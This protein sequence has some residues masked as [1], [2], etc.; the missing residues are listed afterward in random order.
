M[1]L[2]KNDTKNIQTALFR[3]MY[4]LRILNENLSGTS[5]FHFSAGHFKYA[6]V[7]MTRNCSSTYIAESSR[8]FSAIMVLHVCRNLASI[9][10]MSGMVTFCNIN[11]AC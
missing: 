5:Y 9:H 8:A 6:C 11:Y 1:H 4:L 10:V 2:A 3:D 7:Y